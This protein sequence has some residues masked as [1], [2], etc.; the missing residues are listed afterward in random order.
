MMEGRLADDVTLLEASRF[1][2]VR[3]RQ[4]L[5]AGGERIREVVLHP[6]SVVVVPLLPDDRV[7]LIDVVR[8]AVGT[9]LLELPAG[10]LDR[11]ESLA[12]AARREL[13]EETGFLAGRIEPIGGLWM[14]PGILRERMHLFAASDLEAGPQALEP[15][16]QISTRVVS[17]DDAVA[18]CLDGRIEDA[19]TIAAILMINARREARS[20]TPVSDRAGTAPLRGDR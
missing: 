3:R 2:V 6:G 17:W 11:E 12:D 20:P 10:T 18:M 14:S 13:R 5:A 9:T 16:E 8:T 7:C 15:G 1:T 19:K 4:P